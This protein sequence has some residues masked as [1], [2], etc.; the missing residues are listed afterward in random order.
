MAFGITVSAYSIID[1]YK[2]KRDKDQLVKILPINRSNCHL[3][4]TG[5][6]AMGCN[7]M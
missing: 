1:L 4:R 6:L 7:P 2:D 5:M 3:T